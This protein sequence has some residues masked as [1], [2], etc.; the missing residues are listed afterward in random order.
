L[1]GGGFLRG[2]CAVSIVSRRSCKGRRDLRDQYRC[3]A[4]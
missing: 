2:G 3:E 1:A 4:E